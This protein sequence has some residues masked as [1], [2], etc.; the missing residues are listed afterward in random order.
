[1]LYLLQRVSQTRGPVLR[2][3]VLASEAG[4]YPLGLALQLREPM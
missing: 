1:V 4:L 3:Q 2:Q